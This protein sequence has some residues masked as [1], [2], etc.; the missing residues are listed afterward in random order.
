M[1]CDIYGRLLC[2][3]PLLLLTYLLGNSAK[4]IYK[5]HRPRLV[6]VPIIKV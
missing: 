2:S 3:H 4:L 6:Q 5:S 1:D